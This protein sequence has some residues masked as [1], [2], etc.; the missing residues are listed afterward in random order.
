MPTDHPSSDSGPIAWMARHTV[1]ANLVMASFILGG[2][3]VSTQLK[4]E[5]YPQFEVD[6][7]RVSVDYPGASPE[8]IEQGIILG[9]E[10]AVRGLDGVDTVTST[11]KENRAVVNVELVARRQRQRSPARRQQR[12]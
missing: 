11:A 8:E 12:N 10:N 6:V 1:A 2:L 5:V 9:I 7:I 4:Q 3:V